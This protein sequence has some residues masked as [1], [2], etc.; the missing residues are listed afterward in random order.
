MKRI[1]QKLNRINL[2][3]VTLRHF[4]ASRQ[5]GF[6]EFIVLASAEAGLSQWSSTI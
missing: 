6:G 2:G 3:D 5:K 4:L 1:R